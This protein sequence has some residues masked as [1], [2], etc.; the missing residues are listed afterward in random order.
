MP[1]LSLSGNAACRILTATAVLLVLGG[2][3]GKSS[4]LETKRRQV[5]AALQDLR[6]MKPPGVAL[7]PKEGARI[8]GRTLIVRIELP[9]RPWTEEEASAAASEACRVAIQ[10]LQ[11]LGIDPH[12]GNIYVYSY[13]WTRAAKSPTGRDRVHEYGFATYSPNDDAVT[14]RTTGLEKDAPER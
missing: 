6:L 2:C 10:R 7:W 4:P 3:A 11:G 8:A 9:P 13:A 12:R 1:R 5:L 14:F